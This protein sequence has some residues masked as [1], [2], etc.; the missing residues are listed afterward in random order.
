LF[1]VF[2]VRLG[3]KSS[4]MIARFVARQSFIPELKKGMTKGKNKRK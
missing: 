1:I 3:I 2:A 4:G